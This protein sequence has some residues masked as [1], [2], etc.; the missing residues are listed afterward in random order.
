M[1]VVLKMLYGGAWSSGLRKA[2]RATGGKFPAQKTSNQL[3]L[4]MQEH[5]QLKKKLKDLERTLERTHR[6]LA[7]KWRAHAEEP[8]LHA[9]SAIEFES[10]DRPISGVQWQEH[11]IREQ[12]EQQGVIDMLLEEIALNVLS[13]ERCPGNLLGRC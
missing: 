5:E 9:T 3:M 7:R 10:W 13:Q 4:D 12:Q 1:V 8:T 2:E 6:H 11:D